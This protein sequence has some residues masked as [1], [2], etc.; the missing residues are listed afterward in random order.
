MDLYEKYL[1]DCKRLGFNPFPHGI[2]EDI[3]EQFV[4]VWRLYGGSVEGWDWLAADEGMYSE[5]LFE[6]DGTGSTIHY[7]PEG[8]AV[9]VPYHF[10]YR[11][12]E[13]SYSVPW[14]LAVEVDAS[15][16]LFYFVWIDGSGMLIQNYYCEPECYSASEYYK[17]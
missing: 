3:L 1:N 9:K 14:D 11:P 8:E 10:T 5:W 16:E 7:S 6:T 17:R 2:P 13:M 4:G 12:R 15:R